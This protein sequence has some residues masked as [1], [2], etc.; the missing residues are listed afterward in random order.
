MQNSGCKQKQ[1]LLIKIPDLTGKLQIFGNKI[2]I[3]R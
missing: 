1:Q 2:K 3:I